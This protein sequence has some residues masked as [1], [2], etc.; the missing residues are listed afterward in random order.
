MKWRDNEIN[1]IKKSLERRERAGGIFVAAP[2][3]SNVACFL[4]GR[5]VGSSGLNGWAL[6]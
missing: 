6:S 2:C 1:E 4:D 3:R 5:G